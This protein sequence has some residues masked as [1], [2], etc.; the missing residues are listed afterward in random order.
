MNTYQTLSDEQIAKCM[1]NHP[2]RKKNRELV[3]NFLISISTEYSKE[4]LLESAAYEADSSDLD[5][6]EYNTLVEGIER[7]FNKI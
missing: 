2:F 1:Q 5:T 4:E 3:E 6:G 7:L